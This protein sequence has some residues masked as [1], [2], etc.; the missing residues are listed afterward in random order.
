VVSPPA[1]APPPVRV[2]PGDTLR[3]KPVFTPYTVA[4]DLRNRNE[5]AKAMEKAYPSELRA[6]GVGGTAIIYIF[7]EASGEVGNVVI[8][9]GSGHPRL[10][11]AALQIGHAMKFT[12]ARNREA[13]VP[14]WVSLPITFQVR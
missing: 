10:D 1:E 9:A 2:V 3:E 13:V 7:I 12:P 11:E 14:V 8:N 4:P 6:A 5:V